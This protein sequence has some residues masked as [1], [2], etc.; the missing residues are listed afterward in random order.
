MTPEVHQ[1]HVSGFRHIF[2]KLTR[3]DGIFWRKNFWELAFFRRR[4]HRDLRNS[5]YASIHWFMFGYVFYFS[6]LQMINVSLSSQCLP[7]RA[8]RLCTF[9]S[10]WI[11]VPFDPCCVYFYVAEDNLPALS[12]WAVELGHGVWLMLGGRQGQIHWRTNV[13]NGPSIAQIINTFMAF[14]RRKAEVVLIYTGEL[15]DG[16]AEYPRK[17]QR[18]ESK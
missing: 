7:I 11:H 17:S 8:L 13:L 16:R 5:V 6:L 10:I 15:E 12:S 18:K 3:R 2:P 1:S 4:N 9:Q 14:A